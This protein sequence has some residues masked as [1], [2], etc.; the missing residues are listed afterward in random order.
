MQDFTNNAGSIL[1]VGINN[2]DTSITL[3]DASSL[4]TP[5]GGRVFKAALIGLNSN[6][7]ENAWEIVKCTAKASNTLTVVRAQEGTT[8]ASWGVGIRLE[9][10]LTAGFTTAVDD[11][12]DS[13]SNP[14]SVTKAQV[15]LGSADNTAD[16][17]KPVSTAQAAADAAV[18]A[19]AH[20]YA[21]GLVV[22]AWDDRGTWSAVA[23][24]YPATGGRGVGGLPVKGDLWTISAAGTLAGGVVVNIGDVLRALIDSPG[25]TSTN[26][27]VVENNLGYT[28]ENSANKR[29]SFQAT[30]DDTHY[31]SEKL[32]K[33]SL[34]AKVAGNGA[35]T[36]TT[37]TKVTYDA[38]GLVTSGTDATTADIADSTNKRYV[39]DAQSTV[40]GNTSNTNTGDETTATIS[41]KSA[42]SPI[43]LN[44]RKITANFA[45]ASGYNAASVGPITIADGVTVTVGDNATWSIH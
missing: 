27:A 25:Q 12:M 19:S 1:A 21:D 41:A 33:D 26:W 42:D 13:V 14:H 37:K 22:G 32:V 45:I 29:T 17:A 30:P 15:G 24:T 7:Q 2:T 38:K 20:S 4:P 28:A 10:R 31:A 3:A 23:T 18:L 6:G 9:L 43:R 40:L 5:A 44:P 35:I 34:D 36:G 11:H 39:T 16:S 8:A